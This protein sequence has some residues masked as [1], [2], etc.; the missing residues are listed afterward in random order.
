MKRAWSLC[1]SG[2]L[3]IA[4]VLGVTAA[5]AATGKPV[6]VGTKHASLDVEKGQLP[7]ASARLASTGGFSTLGRTAASAADAKVGDEK[8]FLILDD[9][10]GQY[11]LATFTLARSR[12]STSRSGF[13]TT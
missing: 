10:S 8:I 2:V 1:L 3:A 9:V 4:V 12:D 5:T 7:L 11:G 6:D 13:R